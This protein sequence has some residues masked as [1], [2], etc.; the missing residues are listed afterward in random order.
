M[1]VSV[2]HVKMEEFVSIYLTNTNAVVRQVL[3][4]Q[5][6]KQVRIYIAYNCYISLS[7]KS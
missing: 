1:S 4:T 3:R 5:I 7:N 6:V 2:C